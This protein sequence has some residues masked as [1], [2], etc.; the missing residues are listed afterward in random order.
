[1][2]EISE[3]TMVWDKIV[4]ICQNAK[5]IYNSNL[6]TVL[7]LYISNSIVEVHSGKN[8]ADGKVAQFS[9]SLSITQVNNEE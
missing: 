6:G 9:F 2:G 8:N 3:L 4:F 5:A 1:M 7:G